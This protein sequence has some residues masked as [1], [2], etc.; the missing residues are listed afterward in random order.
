MIKLVFF[1]LILVNLSLQ[2]MCHYKSSNK[3]KLSGQGLKNM[4]MRAKNINGMFTIDKSNGYCISLEK[5]KL[6]L[7]QAG[8]IL[9]ALQKNPK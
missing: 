9:D 1:I 8:S 7:E 6:Q 2:N 3:G 5:V 4:K